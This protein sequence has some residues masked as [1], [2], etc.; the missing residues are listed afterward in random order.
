[1]SASSIQ[2][3]L[4]NMQTATA[5]NR[6][7]EMKANGGSKELDG[8]AF[9]M[10]MMEQLKNQDPMNPMDNSEMLAQQAQFTQIQEL[11]KMNETMNQ[12][13]MIQQANSLVGKTVQLVDPNNPARLITG[14]VSSAN[15]TSDSATITVNGK[16]YPL[17]L[18]AAVTD[19]AS[20]SDSS[21][22]SNKKLGDLNN[23][24]GITSGYITIT[25][26]NSNYQKSNSYIKVSNSMTMEE[27]QKELK[28]AGLNSTIT[29]GILTISKGNFKSIGITQGKINDSS[30]IASNLVEKM[31]MFQS[32]TGDLETKVLDFN[33]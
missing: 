22:I 23:A 7:K 5:I 19:G 4:V 10:L 28:D 8:D 31:E 12:N 18:V 3:E 14:L 9:L 30:A 25:T 32:E 26:E 20:A 1:M 21:V 17:G 16:E 2:Q 33:R 15:F 24:S 27:L 13:S 29:N 6:A 11:Q